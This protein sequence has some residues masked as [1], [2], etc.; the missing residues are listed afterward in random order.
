LHILDTQQFAK[1]VYVSHSKAGPNE[2]HDSLG[3]SKRY[4]K[5]VSPSDL[6]AKL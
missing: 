1:N 3:P 2:L 5:L 6:H 4:E